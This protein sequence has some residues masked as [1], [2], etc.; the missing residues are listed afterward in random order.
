V[1]IGAIVMVLAL[2]Y[3]AADRPARRHRRFDVA[4]A[5]SSAAGVGLLAYGVLH[6][7]TT[8]WGST[9]TMIV[10]A[11]A[12]VLLG[13]F[14]I[15]ETRVASEPLVAF[16]LFRNRSL[17]GAN[18]VT[19]LRGAAMFALF[20]FATLSQ[21]QL[22]H[23]SALKTGLAYLPLTAILVIASVSVRRSC[24]AWAPDP[25]C[26]KARWWRRPGWRGSPG[27]PSKAPC[28]EVSSGRR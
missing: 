6:A 2:R 20:Y 25:C 18:I 5:V 9:G 1:P 28:R 22:L 26:S 24:S 12:V 3:L 14:V 13:Y 15:R 27:S 8:G 17:A 10:L 21:Q 19:A 23:Y 16:S 11:A 7:S 4:G